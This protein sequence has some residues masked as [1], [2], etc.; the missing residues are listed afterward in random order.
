MVD[1]IE[2]LSPTAAAAAQAELAR[3]GQGLDTFAGMTILDDC[4]G[5]MH[6]RVAS[7][8]R[9]A[10]DHDVVLCSV[11]GYETRPAAAVGSGGAGVQPLYTAHL[12]E[13]GLM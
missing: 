6:L 7:E 5:V 9:Q 10:G 3:R 1:E 13:L 11:E 12:R 4:Y 2:L 8:P